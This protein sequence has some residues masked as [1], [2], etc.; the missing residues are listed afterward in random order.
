MQ[1]SDFMKILVALCLWL[2]SSTAVV[3]Q[4]ISPSTKPS[5]P[6]GSESLGN[7]LLED[8]PAAVPPARPQSRE[9][10][11]SRSDKSTTRPMPPMENSGED[12]GGPS[13]PLLLVRVR[14]DMRRAEM[15]LGH[16]AAVAGNIRFNKPA[17]CRSGVV[18]QLD[19]LIAELS[20]QCQGG[21]G[22]QS[23]NPSPKPSQRSEAK[24]SKPSRT[25]SP[26]KS[27]ARDSSDPLNRANTQAVD[28]GEVDELV[29]HLWGHLPERSREQVLQSFSDEFLP[30]Y[31]LEIEQ[32]YRR[33]S[34]E[35]GNG[36]NDSTIPQQCVVVLGE[37]CVFARCLGTPSATLIVDARIAR[38]HEGEHPEPVFTDKEQHRPTP[39]PD[40]VVLTWSGDPTTSIDVT[41]R[42]DTT[43]GEPVAEYARAD[44]LV[45]NLREGDVPHSNRVAGSKIEFTSDLGTCQV[46]SAR[47]RNFS[48]RRCTPTASATAVTGASGFNSA[49]PPIRTSHLRSSTLAMLRMRSARFGRV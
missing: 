23:N 40:R 34:E 15:L 30:K 2:I 27:P 6:T 4:A 20:K 28:K 5:A 10:G 16:P 1:R 19:E 38:A 25:A 46:N 9:N 22:Q 21:Q 47:L 14:N 8:L 41:W 49:P 3:G 48:R 29:K 31:E 43:T 45:G 11:T 44:S 17:Q 36:H 37:S 42:T 18:A 12:I 13:G 39:L 24:A 33:L 35:Q 26:G 7:Q 32:Y